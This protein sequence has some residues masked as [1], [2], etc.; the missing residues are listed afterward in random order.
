M[1]L[2]PQVNLL[3]LEVQLT[4]DGVGVLAQIIHSPAIPS[5]SNDKAK[6]VH[7][8]AEIHLNK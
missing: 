4:L 7:V 5:V 8:Y 1:H 2:R 6:H 3:K